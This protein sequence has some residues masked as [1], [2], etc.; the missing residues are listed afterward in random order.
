MFLTPFSVFLL[1]HGGLDFLARDSFWLAS[2]DR[3]WRSCWRFPAITGAA[4]E[5]TRN[6][7]TPP[8]TNPR[9]QYSG[10]QKSISS[11]R[12][13][14]Q[15]TK[16]KNTKWVVCFFCVP[17]GFRFVFFCL[18]CFGFSPRNFL[19]F[20]E[21]ETSTVFSFS[22]FLTGRRLRVLPVYIS[23]V[24]VLML[25]MFLRMLSNL[26]VHLSVPIFVLPLSFLSSQHCTVNAQESINLACL[27]PMAGH[28][29]PP[30][31]QPTNPIESNRS[32]FTLALSA[33]RRALIVVFFSFPVF[34]P[35]KVQRWPTVIT[36]SSTPRHLCCCFFSLCAA[37]LLFRGLQNNDG[38]RGTGSSPLASF[39][40]A[41]IPVWRRRSPVA[42]ARRVP[43]CGR[44]KRHPSS[45]S[46][47]NFNYLLVRHFENKFWIFS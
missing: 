13:W 20:Q 42:A 45:L 28:R 47:H 26:S 9:G 29:D 43:R 10:R 11:S 36:S 14:F 12:S 3:L 37:V 17:V 4:T 2:A 1:W 16:K 34:S 40:G 15:R 44:S 31:S 41:D 30:H 46:H 5:N 32:A 25:S 33:A 8:S 39:N 27:T 7:P 35:P 24:R 6:P 18:L 38:G 22:A 23:F 19:L 21:L